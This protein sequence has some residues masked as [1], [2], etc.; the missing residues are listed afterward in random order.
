MFTEIIQEF[1]DSTDFHK[2]VLA[3]FVTLTRH[4]CVVLFVVIQVTGNAL[5]SELTCTGLHEVWR[6][7]VERKGRSFKGWSE[8]RLDCLACQSSFPLEKLTD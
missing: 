4:L 6:N 3:G 5:R 1:K 2:T 8:G 7:S